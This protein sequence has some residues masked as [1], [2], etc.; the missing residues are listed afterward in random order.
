MPS[1]L[2]TY[3]AA[4]Y[5]RMTSLDTYGGM[6]YNNFGTRNLAFLK[7]VTTG[8]LDLTAAGGPDTDASNISGYANQIQSFNPATS[9]SAE[10]ATTI[11]WADSNSYFSVAVRTIQQFAEVYMVGLPYYNGSTA[12]GFL[13]AVSLDTANSAA[14][15]SVNT[16]VFEVGY[17][18]LLTFGGL[19]A[20][21]KNALNTSAPASSANGADTVGTTVSAVTITQVFP[22]GTSFVAPGSSGTAS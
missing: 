12:S 15:T 13:V 16:E 1:L 3:V 7:I 8:A 6:T 2:G 22:F 18:V 5:G 19:A 20:Q 11:A 14:T 10:T 21:I 9:S 17:P 4:N